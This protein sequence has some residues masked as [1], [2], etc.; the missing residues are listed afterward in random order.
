MKFGKKALDPRRVFIEIKPGREAKVAKMLLSE[1]TG[2]PENSNDPY[3]KHMK[4]VAFYELNGEV[5]VWSDNNQVWLDRG[6]TK[7]TFDELLNWEENFV[8]VINI[9]GHTVE[10]K[11]EYITVGCTSVKLSTIKQ[12][13]EYYENN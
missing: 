3:Y 12:I 5:G 4:L 1:I 2:A 6:Y 9:G 8:P 13:L 7:I 11:E 10:F